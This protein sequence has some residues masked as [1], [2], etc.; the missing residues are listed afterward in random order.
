MNGRRW[1]VLRASGVDTFFDL[2]NGTFV[3][4]SQNPTITS[5]GN[6]WYRCTVQSSSATQTFFR[7]SNDGTS[8]SYPG[9]GAS[10]VFLWGA[11]LEAGA[12]PTSYIPTTIVTAARSADVCTITSSAFNSF[13]NQS[14]GTFL[15]KTQLFSIGNDYNA[16]Y[17][18]VFSGTSYMRISVFGQTSTVENSYLQNNDSTLNST[19]PSQLSRISRAA[20]AYQLNNAR[21]VKNGTLGVL[22]TIFTPYSNLIS[23]TIMSQASGTME[24]LRYYRKRLPDAK[25]QTLTV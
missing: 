19:V 25:L 10:G 13:Y 5:F 6:G 23:L 14:E 11:Q 2:Q 9:D 12:F 15:S 17:W 4:T 7:M 20:G 1:I 24:S 8:V 18:N 3:N 21:L 22:D 16:S